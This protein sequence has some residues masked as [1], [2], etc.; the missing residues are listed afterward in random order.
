MA[1]LIPS[2]N[3]CLGRMQAGEKRFARRL[4]EKLE[5]DYLL[6][7]DVPIGGTGHH[8]DFIILHPRRGLLVLEVKDWKRDTLRSIDKA[9][10]VLMTQTGLKE[11]ANPFEQSRV[12]AQEIAT[13]LQR[14]P[15]LVNPDGPHRG[16]LVLPWSHGVVLSNI[17]RKQFDEGDLG[18]VLP[19]SRVICRDE[20][21]EDV[22]PERF[23]KRLWD[24]FPWSPSQPISL[25]QLDRIR[26]HVFPELRIGSGPLARSAPVQAELELSVPD[27]IRIMD[28]QQE[29]LAR[30][31]GEGHR[32]I[33]GVAGSGKTMILGYRCLQLART[34]HR[35]ILVLCYGKPLYGWLEQM[36]RAQGLS[37]QVVIQT[38]HAWCHTQLRHFHVGLPP[39]GLSSGD[40]SEQLVQ[41]VIAAVD[42]GLIPRA[43]YG[44]VLIDEG[45]DFHPEWFKLISQMVDPGTNSLLLLYDDAQSIYPHKRFSFRSVGIQAQGRTTILRLNYRNTAD[46]LQF[47]ADFAREVL[48]PSDAD[49][50]G[51]PLVQPQSAGRRGP[52]PK[53]VTLPNLH[54]ELSYIGGRFQQLHAE[55]HAWNEMALLYRS[56]DI[57][58][59]A[60]RHLNHMGIP[61]QWVGKSPGQS[62]FKSSEASVKVLTFHSSKG[63]EFPV[64][65]IP[66]LKRPAPERP[67]AREEARLLYVAMT[68]AMDQLVLT[69]S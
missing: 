17:T 53:V 23:Q 37:A 47:A 61:L 15:M 1:T 42:R 45:H 3:Q 28:L 44:A 41:R 38:F 20:M 62:A 24:M 16:R 31:L 33:H 29:Q 54:E 27:L 26:W 21:G 9:R 25:P 60:V 14:D 2:L 65:A 55:G 50:D 10:A 11:V 32:V 34:L 66:R 35:P 67:D 59:R 48:T 18:K 36:L 46:I 56:S 43:Q 64:V 8:P 13:L 58:Q 57:G 51:V 69:E 40:F 68:R 39:Q 52:A 6:W 19:P 7:Y 30:S 12:Y 22:D 63:L 4:E 49:E 5:D